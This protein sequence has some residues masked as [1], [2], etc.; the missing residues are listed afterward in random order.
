MLP[1][2]EEGQGL[3]SPAGRRMGRRG[4]LISPRPSQPDLN[5]GVGE[6]DPTQVR[7]GKELLLCVY[8]CRKALGGGP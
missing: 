7:C 8:T 6:S 4:L 2:V 3:K 1:C 5:R